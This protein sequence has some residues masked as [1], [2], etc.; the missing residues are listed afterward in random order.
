MRA[1]QWNWLPPGPVVPPRLWLTAAAGTLAGLSILFQQEIWPHHPRAEL[2]G[3]L[4]LSVLVQAI[5]I[6]VIKVLVRWLR[7]C[8]GPCWAQFVMACV[9]F[10]ACFAMALLLLITFLLMCFGLIVS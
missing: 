3:W 1:S 9:V 10:P 8:T 7:A 4:V 6:Q 2:W 5:C